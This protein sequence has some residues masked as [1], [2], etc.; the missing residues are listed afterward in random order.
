[1]CGIAGWWQQALHPEERRAGVAAMVRALWHRG[2]DAQAVVSDGEATLG[3]ARLAIVDR[4]QGQQPMARDGALLAYNGEL[5]N[6]A[7]LRRELEQRGHVFRTV[8]DTEVVL[9]AH[10]TWGDDAPTRFDGMF[11]Y[12]LWHA[13]R[14]E[15]LLVRDRLGI[16]PLYWSKHA[17]GVAFASEPK[18]L[19]AL[20]VGRGRPD[21]HG[22]LEVFAHGAA[23]PAGVAVGERTCFED[24][25]AILP[26]SWL[27]LRPEGSEQ[28]TWWRFVDAIG[29]PFAVPEEGREALAAAFE[30]SVRACRQGEAQV[31][32][33]L[34]GG[35]DSSL[36]TAELVRQ[37]TSPVAAATITYRSDASDPDAAAAKQV[38]AHLPT[39]R[40]AHHFTYLPESTYFHDLDTLVRAF[41]EP[42][43]EPRKLGML[44]NYR[45]LRAAGCAVALSGEGADELF[46]GYYPRFAGWRAPEPATVADFKG[47][48]RG[49]LGAVRT[50]V[51][52]A[53]AG[54]LIDGAALDAVVDDSVDR[55]LA[56][57]WQATGDRVRAVQAWYT[58]TFLHW[59]LADNDRFGMAYS[60][61]G[62]FPFLTNAMVEVALRMPPAWNFP[63]VDGLPD[64]A[65]ARWLGQGRLPEA[66]WRQ[67][68]KAP[69][70]TPGSLRYHLAIA[71]RLEQEIA[72]A[73]PVAWAW[74]DRAEVE[75]L[76]AA[77]RATVAPLLATAPDDGEA[78]TRYNPKLPVRTVHLFSVL[79]TL[80]W[81][82]LYG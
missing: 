32:A 24:I 41:D 46:F 4:A 33:C 28:R 13:G 20:A 53:L 66:I 76:I 6:H 14:H 3:V 65:Q 63:Q 55:W 74:F 62:R 9:A 36:L 22:L 81:L 67:R 77:F 23:F 1:M 8:S 68:V 72:L 79:T 25:H 56:P 60:V 51:A 12:A 54:G 49:K 71:D 27:R 59:L 7:E 64:K 26:A 34:S 80:R 29:T 10:A 42:C 35:L 16:K 48:W 2:P 11:A 17:G 45:T 73:P 82:A 50:L 70:P 78:V 57:T 75:R 61:E 18:A 21:W 30:A 19:L 5:Y 58:H 43:W 44:A 15:L 39:G 52:P 40:L 38:A 37:T 47:L 31:G 69:M